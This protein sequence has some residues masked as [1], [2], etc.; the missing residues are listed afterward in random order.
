V[1]RQLARIPLTPPSGLLNPLSVGAINEFWY[2][3]APR[4]PQLAKPHH[5]TGFFHPLDGI[6]EWNRFYGRPRF[7]LADPVSEVGRKK[8]PVHVVGRLGHACG[9]S[10][11]PVETRVPE[12]S[13]IARRRLFSGIRRPLGAKIQRGPCGPVGARATNFR[14]CRGGPRAEVGPPGVGHPRCEDRAAESLP[15]DWQ[16]QA[17]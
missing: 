5:M 2:R 13:L 10:L 15:V 4:E 1:P 3:K 7:P 16:S 6:G 17:E 9:P 8:N 12:T 14:T 11:G